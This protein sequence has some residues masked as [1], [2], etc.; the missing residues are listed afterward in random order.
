[1]AVKLEYARSENAPA[2]AL[3]AA[4]ALAFGLCSGPVGY[5][6]AALA[7]RREW[8]PIAARALPYCLFGAFIFGLVVSLTL[9]KSA[10]RRLRVFASVG[11]VAPIVWV[12]TLWILV[13][14]AG[15]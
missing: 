5:A 8:F 3:V 7:D 15:E 6:L 12:L 14:M 10:A 4:L 13:M 2:T 11:M 1:M 9:P